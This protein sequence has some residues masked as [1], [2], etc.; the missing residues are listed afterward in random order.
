MS[1]N[2]AKLSRWRVYMKRLLVQLTLCGLVMSLFLILVSAL[3]AQGAE[4]KKVMVLT[5]MEGVDGIFDIA[6]QVIPFKSPRW[7]ESRKLLTGE[8]N[9]AVDG[10]LEAG[11]TDVIIWDGH[12]D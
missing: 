10:L 4:A 8:I 7:E 12:W 1:S 2:F 11:A 3:A 9:A 5:D 6:Q